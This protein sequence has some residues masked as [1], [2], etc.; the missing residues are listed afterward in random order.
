M[1]N[2]KKRLAANKMQRPFYKSVLVSN[3]ENIVK[4]SWLRN[5]IARKKLPM[6]QGPYGGA[7]SSGEMRYVSIYAHD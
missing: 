6:C 2:P 3:K 5:K 4:K 7:Q 1:G